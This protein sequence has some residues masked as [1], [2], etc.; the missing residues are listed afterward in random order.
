MLYTSFQKQIGNKI[1]EGNSHPRQNEDYQKNR[2]LTKDK[3][4]L[5]KI[6]RKRRVIK[7]AGPVHVDSGPRW[8]Q[9]CRSFLLKGEKLRPQ[10]GIPSAE[11]QSK[12]HLTI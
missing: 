2:P 3:Q 1:K 12:H 10:I 6:S 4:K 9:C 7:G 11:C 5:P 8:W